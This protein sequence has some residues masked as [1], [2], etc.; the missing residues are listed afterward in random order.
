MSVWLAWLSQYGLL[1]VFAGALIEGEMLILMAGILTHQGVL[2]F[3]PTILV[4][5]LGAF[6]GDQLWFM[7]GRH[8][9]ETALH[10]FP[11]LA[12]HADRVA[13]W[14]TRHA[15]RVALLA[16]F[17]YGVRSAAPLLLGVT[18]YSAV[19]FALINGF[20]SAIWALAVVSTGH[21]ISALAVKLFG[22]IEHLEKYLLLAVVLGMSVVGL[23][24]RLRSPSTKNTR[25]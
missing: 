5:T 2:P 8:Y 16:R 21:F 25:G 6:C 3:Q 7:V 19:R 22:D 12:S 10:R 15:D 1:L 20:S 24:R 14:L 4:A 18:R 13:P 23:A 11:R 17:V 9:G